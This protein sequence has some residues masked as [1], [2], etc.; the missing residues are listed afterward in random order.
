[1]VLVAKLLL[2]LEKTYDYNMETP[3][4]GFRTKTARSSQYQ[5]T[6]IHQIRR[7]GASILTE[8]I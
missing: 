7:R 3:L 6:Q 4:R 5:K 1:M 2:C 8:S